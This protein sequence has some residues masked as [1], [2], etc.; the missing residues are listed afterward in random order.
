MTRLV[1]IIRLAGRNLGDLV[2]VGTPSRSIPLS[3]ISTMEA[4]RNDFRVIGSDM[5]VTIRR[6]GE[7]LEKAKESAD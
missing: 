7:L 6:Q 5:R 1:N 4:L 3:R 2:S